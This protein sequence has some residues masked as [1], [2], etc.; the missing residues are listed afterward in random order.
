MIVENEMIYGGAHKVAGATTSGVSEADY[1]IKNN[2]R[3]SDL[4]SQGGEDIYPGTI[5]DEE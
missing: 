1:R 4:G 3:K 5:G 2:Q